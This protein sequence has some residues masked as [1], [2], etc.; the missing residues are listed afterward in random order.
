MPPPLPE[1]SPEPMPKAAGSPV[2]GRADRAT[3]LLADNDTSV[4][5]LLSAIL[6]DSGVRCVSVFDGEQALARL[7]AGDI[8]VLVTDL[9]MP[10]LNG[11]QLLDRL[12]EIEPLPATLVISGYLDRASEEELR[13]HPAVCHV[14]RKPFDVAEFARLVEQVARSRPSSASAS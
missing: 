9:D 4:N 7:R 12:S 5:S 14:L 2:A 8:D 3:V 1:P 6:A 13:G 10:K 11:R